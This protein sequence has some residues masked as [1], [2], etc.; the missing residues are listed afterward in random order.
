MDLNEGLEMNFFKKYNHLATSKKRIN[1]NM[2][3]EKYEA[4]I[5][6]QPHVTIN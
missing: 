4:Q 1:V 3:D 6:T 5:K 2:L